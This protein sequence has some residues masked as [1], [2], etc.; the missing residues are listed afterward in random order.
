M[1]TMPTIPEALALALQQHQSGQLPAAESICR[2]ILEVEPAHAEALHLLE[3]IN[4][5]PGAQQ[6][7]ID[8]IYRNLTA[9]PGWA[10]IQFNLANTL[11]QQ[12]NLDDAIACYRRALEAKP[13]FID[14]LNNLGIA[15][16][17]RGNL[18][19]AAACYRRGLE[20]NPGH[21]S[22]HYNLAIA[23]QQQGE[24]E[25]AITS[26]RRA[27]LLNP[28][29]LNAHINL[30]AAMQRQGNL[31]EAIACY[32]RALELKPDFADAHNNLG[33]ALK[34][35]G[36]LAEAI[37]CYRRAL[38][39]KPDYVDAYSNL[40]S[41]LRDQGKLDESVV[42]F[43]RALELKPDLVT[44]LS[45]LV[46]DLQH[47]CCWEELNEL[48]RRMIE[49]V[50]RDADGGT[51]LPV[52]PFYFLALP[53]ITTPAQQL[54]CARRWVE[55]QLK[56][57]SETGRNL[58]RK[59]AADRKITIG[60]LSADFHAHATAWLI[61]ELIE[62]HDRDRFAVFGYSYGPD[63]GSPT[64][65]RLVSGFDRFVDVKAA[66][67]VDAA[68]RI[69]ADDVDILIDLKGYTQNT[70]T[71]I[72]AL[73]TAPLQVNYLGYPGTM[74]APFMDYILV[75]EF[76]VP[77]EQQPF[78]TEK[79]V[80]LPGCYQVNDSQREISKQTPS[81]AACGLPERGFVFC[82]FN[83]GYKI[84]PEMFDV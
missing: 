69:A 55:H 82:S 59:Q 74:G 43:R 64:R 42:C 51:A 18:V 31:E 22:M 70:R 8:S 12:G 77:P 13:D 78:F 49:F 57:K 73:R 33:V 19:E 45:F 54:R 11:R 39:L 52:S 29:H 72:L 35:R 16:R 67:F 38:D 20:L 25:Q 1:T 32:R 61:A 48:S 24:L 76:I 21:A 53:M 36:E 65:R 47:L 40:G 50:E 66:S 56:A 37:A 17:L 34:D 5:P 3:V 68:R 83:N 41:A 80:H 75:D 27:L 46:H 9:K 44:A 28:G 4:A 23:L 10:E 79:L 81:R 6:L 63:D 7:A 15:L 2:Q 26:Y 30:G 60:Y 71:E 14:A 84:T 62:K 58:A